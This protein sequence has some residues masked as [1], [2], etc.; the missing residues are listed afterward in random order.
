MKLLLVNSVCGASSTGRIV[1]DLYDAASKEG[2]QCKIAYGEHRH[3]NITEGYDTIKIGSSLDN[4]LHAIGTRITDKHGLYSK[5]AT[6][7]FLKQVDKWAPDVI[8]LHNLHGYYLNYE[9]LFDYLKK[10][11]NIKVFWTL[12]DCF[13]LTGH[14]VYFS[15]VGCTKWKNGCETCPL[16]KTYPAS[17]I[18]DNSKDNYR[19]KMK[20]FLGV[21]NMT[22][23]VPSNWLKNLVKES[24][25]KD[26]PVEV[27]NNGVDIS[28][29]TPL[30]EDTKVKFSLENKKVI[31]GVANIW[32][33]NKG[34]RYYIKLA[35]KYI[36]EKRDDVEIVIVGR[37]NGEEASLA[38]NMKWIPFTNSK[39][40]LNEIYNASDIYLSFSSEETFGM[41]IVE[42]MAAGTYP[43]AMKDTACAE[44]IEESVGGVCERN[45][46]SAYESIE[47]FF[48]GYYEDYS[49]A[50]ISFWSKKYSL[51][52][53]T[54]QI[55]DLYKE[56]KNGM[57]IE[58]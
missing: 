30:S 37:T 17:L 35:E 36:E 1:T 41:T 25:L 52:R 49:K 55:I 24:F 13:A 31:L 23:L 16:K 18:R 22:I 27:V 44:I 9:M 14:C 3:P 51:N 43:L 12:H 48:N 42:A 7:D 58:K 2:I 54:S 45:V 32:A 40:E 57:G 34:L 15:E 10:H 33:P 38:S 53:F 5:E 8:H 56:N 39:E 50:D 28:A 21:K 6:K 46:D 4:Y 20:A 47:K 11:E 29:F 19:R 26:Y